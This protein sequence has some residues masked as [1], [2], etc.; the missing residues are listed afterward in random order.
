M[1]AWIDSVPCSSRRPN[2]TIHSFAQRGIMCSFIMCSFGDIEQL[3]N[4]DLNCVMN[5]EIACINNVVVV[6]RFEN[7]S[8][9]SSL[10]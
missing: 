7:K 8:V 4:A 5:C 6:C 10:H 9:R 2:P 1:H 3:G